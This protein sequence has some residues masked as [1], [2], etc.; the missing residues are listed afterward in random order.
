MPKYNFI[1]ASL[2]KLN[3]FMNIEINL[4]KTFQDLKHFDIKIKN[5]SFS[6]NK[7]TNILNNVNLEIKEREHVLIKGKSGSGKSTICNLLVKNEVLINGSILIGDINIDDINTYTMKKN[8]MYVSQKELLY[9]DTIKNNIMFFRK[10]SLSEF[11]QI[12]KLCCVD[13][14]ID[15]KPLRYETIVSVDTNNLS[16]GEK[17]RVV[18]ARALLNDFKILIID[19]ALSEVD[20]PTEIK[21]IK[22]I[23]KYFKDKTIIYISH[24]NL[25]QSFERTV[26]V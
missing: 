2:D 4:D 13:E 5:A 8:I 7:L 16:G 9:T 19:E 17:Q 26:Y 14:I 10:K 3:E 15:S 18:L 1:K 23:Q 22:N 20:I 12:C 11:D 21:I 24:K 6:Y 25:S